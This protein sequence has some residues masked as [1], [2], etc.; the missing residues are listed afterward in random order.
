MAT[1]RLEQHEKESPTTK[2]WVEYLTA[3][4]DE[5]RD[6]LE[7]PALPADETAAFRGRIKFIKDT[8]K[9]VK[10]ESKPGPQAPVPL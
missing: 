4:R 8:L 10:D 3:E 9:M 6:R 5:L 7:N 1:L 2:K